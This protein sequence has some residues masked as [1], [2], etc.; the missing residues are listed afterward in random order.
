MQKPEMKRE[1]AIDT[2]SP[3]ARLII[4]FAS[5]DAAAAFAA[6]GNMQPPNQPGM[7]YWLYADPRFDFNE[8]VAYI[9]NYGQ[10]EE[11]EDDNHS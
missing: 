4:L 1:V 5:P 6:F 3:V 2:V 11:E 10:E 9:Q 8:V 7:A